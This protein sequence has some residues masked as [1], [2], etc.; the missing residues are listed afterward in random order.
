MLVEWPDNDI[1]LSEPRDISVNRFL[2]WV[3]STQQ[4][5]SQ[6]HGNV[7]TLRDNKLWGHELS[8]DTNQ[9]KVI[10]LFGIQT[11]GNTLTDNSEA[12]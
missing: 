3:E 6:F 8:L 5:R 2:E 1:H 12:T 7:R 10:R 4:K 9:R 11:M